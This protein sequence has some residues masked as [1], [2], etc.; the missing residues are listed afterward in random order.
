M[1]HLLSMSFPIYKQLDTMDCGPT[2]LRMVAKYY[3]KSYSLQTLRERSFITRQGVS[4]L[5]ISDAA[6]AIGLRTLGARLAFKQLAHDVPLPCIVHWKQRHFVVVYK[7]RKGKVYVAD[8]GHGLIT[9][10]LQEFCANWLSTKR[11]GEERG[12]ALLLEPAPEFYTQPDDRPNKFGFIFILAYLTPYRRY[13]LQLA[14]GLGVGSGL[15]LIVPFLTQALVDIG[16][17]RQQLNFLYVVLIAQCALSLSRLSVNFI[18]GW[19][20]LHISKRINIAIISDFLIKLMRLPVGF[21]D[22]KMT[23]DLLQRIKDHQRIE[24]FLTSSSLGILFALVNLVVFG[25][26]LAIYNAGMFAIFAT[27]SLLYV[28]W[29][30][31][32]MKTRRDLDFK[33]F[34]QLSENQSN[35]I[36]L[37]TGMQE[38]KLHNCEQPKR[39]EW[40]RIQ[41]RLFKIQVKG[42]ALQ[43]YQQAGAFAMHEA[44]NILLTFCAA[45]AV[46]QGEMTLGMM[47]S[48]QYILGQLNSPIEQLI[49]FLYAGQDAK[50]SLERLGEI[51]QRQDEESPEQ[52]KIAILPARK[53]L[54]LTNVAFQYA[55]PH[56]DYVLRDIAL[57]LPAGKVSAIVGAS[58]SGKTTLLKLLLGFYPPTQGKICVGDTNLVHL[59]ERFWRS[60]CG[61]VMQDGFIFSDTIAHNIAVSAEV[62]DPE[63]LLYAVHVANIQEMIESLPLGYNT[64]IGA[65][66]MGLSQGQK[67]RILIA[68]AVYKDPEYLFFDEAT[69][70]LDANN[71]RVIMGNLERFFKGRTVVI[72]AHRL[73]TVKHADQ[74]VVLEKGQIIETGN[75]QELARMQGAYYHLVKNQLEL[76]A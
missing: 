43:N 29:I 8:P 70:A 17:Q 76:G 16:I 24:A 37:I 32:F 69:N 67:Q 22:T 23:G 36:Q 12:V 52:G 31:V 63:K 41:A 56:S 55:G 5:G 61:V 42:L 34:A 3:G 26:V 38:I 62:I 44:Q 46:M 21:F 60:Q 2:C 25:G 18:R 57:C 19:I 75:H 7:I 10:T 54:T 40:E 64:Q 68:R 33:Q 74:I 73:S 71:E 35:L 66:G 11:D 48:V 27:G 49:G 65:D 58:G 72:V 1:P 45:N 28:A 59:S 13:L 53:D 50:I 30:L 39:W 14:L 47:L 9:Y 6:E 15:Q 20:L 4:M 51:H